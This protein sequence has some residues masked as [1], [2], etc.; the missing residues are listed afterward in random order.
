[1]TISIAVLSLAGY[2]LADDTFSDRAAEILRV[3]FI[4]PST[5]MNPNLNYAQA[6]PNKSPGRSV[7]IIDTHIWTKWF[8]MLELLART[9]RWPEEDQ[10]KLRGWF[11]DYLEWMLESEN[12]REEKMRSNNHATWWTAQTAAV[13]HYTGREDLIP[14]LAEHAR[15]HLVAGQIEA[16]GRC[17]EEEA[18]TRSYDY[19]LFN[20]DA[21]GFLCQAL[22]YYGIDL[23]E[24]SN[25]RGGSVKKALD[26]MV[27]F[28]EN[29][30]KWGGE[31]ITPMNSREPA[32]LF[33]A[34]MRYPGERYL[35]IYRSGMT[36]RKPGASEFRYD[37][38]RLWL[39][40]LVSADKN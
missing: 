11:A 7:G 6:I 12:G 9:G 13:A 35:D 24:W 23:W 29:P 25:E 18:R 4:D 28:I 30:E 34:G 22:G 17:P 36:V 3:W 20:L 31:Q 5:R 14:M 33:F 39:N 21:F 40:L 26:Y 1:M 10:D 8:G 2:Y 15:S 16:D 38:F 32:I 19:T 27:P 37:P